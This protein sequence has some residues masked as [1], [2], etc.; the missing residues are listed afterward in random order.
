MACP[1]GQVRNA[2][3]ECVNKEDR[4]ENNFDTTINGNERI[5]ANQDII[6]PVKDGKVTINTEFGKNQGI[7]RSVPIDTTGMEVND[8]WVR[9]NDDDLRLVDG[10]I[11]KQ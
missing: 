10:K 4:P 5:Y 1:E 9:D 11:V 2:A 7:E 6:S 8:D 3:G